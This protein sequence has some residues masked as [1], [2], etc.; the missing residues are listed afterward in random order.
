M[1]SYANRKTVAKALSIYN[2]RN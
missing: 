1:C 2:A